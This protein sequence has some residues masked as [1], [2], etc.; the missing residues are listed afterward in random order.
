MIDNEPVKT[1]Y[2]PE[3]EWYMN[4]EFRGQHGV[5]TKDLQSCWKKQSE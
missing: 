5:E 3:F 2:K 4:L 1:E